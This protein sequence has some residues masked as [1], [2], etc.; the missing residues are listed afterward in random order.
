MGWLPCIIQGVR[1]LVCQ[2]CF[3]I[4]QSYVDVLQNPFNQLRS[5]VRQFFGG[6]KHRVRWSLTFGYVENIFWH[7]SKNS[8]RLNSPSLPL[9]F[10]PF[11]L[12]KFMHCCSF[13][14]SKLHHA[15]NE[16]STLPSLNL[17]T[18][19]PFWEQ[20]W[21]EQQHTE[22][23]LICL[24]TFFNQNLRNCSHMEAFYTSKKLPNITD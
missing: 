19:L 3:E 18:W 6:M 4:S 9:P 11:F 16:A 22:N 14:D 7:N 10:L 15:M 24:K 21:A 1:K 2:L 12:G 23:L 8:K 20:F 17:C 13:S 5:D